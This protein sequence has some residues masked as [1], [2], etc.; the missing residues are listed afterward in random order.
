MT[1]TIVDKDREYSYTVDLLT[2]HVARGDYGMGI[3]SVFVP[4]YGDIIVADYDTVREAAR[5]VA[6]C[7]MSQDEI[8]EFPGYSNSEN[9]FEWGSDFE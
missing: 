6:E 1:K 7:L 2:M 3:V 4:G 9:E 8:Y 5:H